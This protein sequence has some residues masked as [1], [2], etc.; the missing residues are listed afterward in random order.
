MRVILALG[1]ILAAMACG[2][3]ITVGERRTV[4][5]DTKVV[6]AWSSAASPGGKI[7]VASAGGS[8]E[9]RNTVRSVAPDN[10]NCKLVF[11]KYTEPKTGY[12]NSTRCDNNAFVAMDASEY[13][14]LRQKALEKR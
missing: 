6:T 7:C 9:A 4:P 8:L 5:T 1:A 14:E 12:A 13:A 3:T 2:P 10:R 11:A